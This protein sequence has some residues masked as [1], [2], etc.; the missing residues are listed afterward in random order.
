MVR[1]Q[2]TNRLT[3]FR[4][5]YVCGQTMITTADTPFMRQLP[6]VDGKKQKTCYFCSESCKQS[7]YI[8]NFDGLAW[9]RKQEYEAQRDTK[10]KNRRFYAAHAEEMRERSRAQRAA[11][12]E[13]DKEKERIYRRAYLR[14]YRARK[15]EQCET[16]CSIPT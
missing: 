3:L 11:M 12:T 16:T 2:T 6:N 10:E 5:C 4:T 9:K 1:R 8:H 14:D 7:T 15:K 13:E